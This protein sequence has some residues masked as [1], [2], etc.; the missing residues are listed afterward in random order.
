[1][2]KTSSFGFIVSHLMQTLSFKE[3][4]SDCLHMLALNFFGPSDL[5]LTSRCIHS[6]L[7]RSCSTDVSITYLRSSTQRTA[8]QVHFLE[9][10]QCCS[11]HRDGNTTTATYR[12]AASVDYERSFTPAVCIVCK[13][14]L[15]HSSH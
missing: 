2:S 1:M 14:S 10:P 11:R 8:P 15:S 6:L 7:Q 9:V 12:N 3:S 4:Q 5:P 13:Q